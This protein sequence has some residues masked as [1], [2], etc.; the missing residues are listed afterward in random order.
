MKK[1]V[2]MINVMSTK[3]KITV[4]KILKKIKTLDFPAVEENV[5][6]SLVD[7]ILN[8]IKM[9]QE[10]VDLTNLFYCNYT[11]YESGEIFSNEPVQRVLM[12]KVFKKVNETEHEIQ[13][14]MNW[15]CY[16]I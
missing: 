10:T 11:L 16:I 8:A 13:V 5:A 14:K 4:N 7:A 9:G 3:N 12:N 2:V 6:T 15:W 1:R